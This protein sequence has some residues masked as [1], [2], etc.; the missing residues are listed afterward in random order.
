MVTVMAWV[1]TSVSPAKCPSFTCCMRQAVSS[2]TTL[3]SR[4]SSKSATGGS[5]KARCPFSPMPRQHRSSGWSRQQPGVATAL[6][7]GIAQ[8][9]HVVRRLGLRPVHDALA[10]PALEPG[11]VIRVRRPRIRPCGRRPSRT[12][13]RPRSRVTSVCTNASW[14]FPV[15]NI[16]WATPRASTA[17]CMNGERLVGGGAGHGGH[18]L[19]DARRSRRRRF[20]FRVA[21][22]QHARR[23]SARLGSCAE[24][25]PRGPPIWSRHG[26]RYAS[27]SPSPRSWGRHSWEP[28]CRRSSRRS[29]RPVRSRCVVASL[30]SQRPSR[31]NQVVPSSPPRPAITASALPTRRPS[32]ARSVTVVVPTGASA[33]KVAALEQFDVRLVLH[34]EGYREAERH[35]LELAERDG[36]PLRVALQRSRRHRRAGHRGP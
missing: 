35:A 5:L 15:A 14:E 26:R 27:T 19:V 32:S 31:R 12:T 1:G 6:F 30:P 33:A 18:V 22:V 16:A 11:G 28:L 29:S 13:G 21:R 36:R 4:G 10:D 17:A 7:L 20:W 24:W 34:G 9:L 25:R 2:S 3:T 8:T 23:G